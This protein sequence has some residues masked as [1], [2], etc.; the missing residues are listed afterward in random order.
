MRD[1]FYM[2]MINGSFGCP[3]NYC[4]GCTLIFVDKVPLKSIVD[5]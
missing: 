1:I 2:S 4:V 5:E 3:A